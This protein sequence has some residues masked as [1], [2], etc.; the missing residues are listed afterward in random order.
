MTGTIG[1]TFALYKEQQ[2]G[3]PV[4]IETQNVHADSHGHYT[5]LL[6]A[7][8]T[9]GLAV[10]LFSS[11]EARWLGVQ[12]AGAE[13]QPRVLLLSVPYALKAADA[14]TLGGKPA[15]AFTLSSPLATSTTASSHPSV[16][17]PA[18]VASVSGSGTPGYI[19]RWT[20][21]SALGNSVLF[22]NSSGFLGLGTTLPT[23]KFQVNSG[24][25]LIKGPNNFVAAGNQAH[26][27][28]G[29]PNH[30]IVATYG[31]GVSIGAVSAANA[32]F[33]QDKTGNV[34][35][36]TTTPSSRLVVNGLEQVGTTTATPG[37]ILSTTSNSHS[38]AGLVANGFGD[39]VT[40]TDGIH[41]FGGI[42]MG[43]TNFGSGNGVVGNGGGGGAP[44]VGGGDGVVG[45][46]GNAGG[47][48]GRGLVGTGG[49]SEL[50]GDGV[51]G[52]G[53]QGASA[54]GDGIFGTNVDGGTFAASGAYAGDFKGDLNVTGAIFAGTKDF[55]IDHPLDPA[56]KYLIHASVE[57]SEMLNVYSG[58]LVL[59]GTGAAIV[60]L[61]AWFEAENSDFRYQLTAIG[62]AGPGLYVAQEISNHKFKIAGG[63]PG[64]KVSW[65]VTAV[66]QDAFA[67][68]HPVVVEQLKPLRERG[69]YIHP[70][71][72]GAPQESGVEWARH[73]K[74]M[75]KIKN[76]R[77][78]NALRDSNSRLSASKVANLSN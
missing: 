4:W 36:G 67:K 17:A 71:L 74:L 30:F 38:Y 9:E 73:P 34:G 40:S 5:A 33:I 72:F 75:H 2:G 11:G 43:V 78:R 6:G 26:L 14:E 1:V 41:A 49:S 42:G 56:N 24:D 18:T 15:S 53:G 32:V 63:H 27:Y 50:G 21:T 37:A 69:F 46:G 60:T 59:D 44:S 20:G 68:A 57:S 54:D 52:T 29:G 25:I 47:G 77:T 51:N 10:E 66:R 16:A 70:E 31:L 55:K 64:G 62:A 28:L 12:I 48:G 39:T 13:E 22:Q 45:N 76:L 35:I 23:Q 7:T 61:P 65:Q 58:N 3:A 8:K 19:A